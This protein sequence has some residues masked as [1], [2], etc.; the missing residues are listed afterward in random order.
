M[1]VFCVFAHI[2][3]C[4]SYTSSKTFN[5]MATYLSKKKKKKEDDLMHKL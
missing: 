1:L 4:N 2:G 3:F 5:T